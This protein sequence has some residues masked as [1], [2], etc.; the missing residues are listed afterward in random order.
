MLCSRYR[1]YKKLETY[2]WQF[3]CPICGDSVNNPHKSRGY[4]FKYKD[5]FMFKCHRC[6]ASMG[7]AS[8]LKNQDPNLFKEYVFAKFG[9]RKKNIIE[10]IPKSS[11][12]IFKP[13]ISIPKNMIELSKLDNDHYANKYVNQRLIPDNIKLYFSDDFQALV[14]SY[15]PN[16]FKKPFKE[17]RLI[18]PMID[19]SGVLFGFQGRSFDKNTKMRYI[20]ILI[21]EDRQ[22]LY[23]LDRIDRSKRVYVTEGPIDSMFLENGISVCGSDLL[24]VIGLFRDM[25]FIWDNECRAK[26][27]LAKMEKAISLGLSVLIWN[28][29]NKYK[30]INDMVMNNIHIEQILKDRV[31]RGLQAK[32]ELA[33]WRKDV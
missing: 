12:P 5:S 10:V 24:G 23:G 6:G 19:S 14:N 2:S 31:F 15:I 21:D 29:S 16:K 7:F 18:I 11:K 26:P 1:N 8:L 13:R 28:K 3:S 20:T 4:I 30:D 22:R 25:V 27:I 9:S 17:E 33:N 32:L